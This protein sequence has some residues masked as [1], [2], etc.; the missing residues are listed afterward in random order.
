MENKVGRV[1]LVV[2]SFLIAGAAMLSAQGHAQ[3]VPS[4]KQVAEGA[5]RTFNIPAQ[6]MSS[7]LVLFGQ[8]AGRH[9]TVDGNLVR[10]LSTAGVQGTMAAD[11][12]L[13]RLL[14]GTDLTFSGGAGGTFTVHR[15]DQPGSSGALQLDPVQVQG[16]F[17]VPPTGMIDNIPPPYAG[18]QVATGGQLGL[19]GNR[20]VMDTP[21]NQTSYTAKKAADQQ[22]K[23]VKDVLVDDPSVRSFRPESSSGFDSVYIRG[24]D[25]TADS[26]AYGGLYGMLPSSSVNAE[27]AERV[28]VLKGPS[29]MLNGMP[30][31]GIIGGT[32]NVVPKRAA[33]DDLTQVTAS[34]LSAGQF[35]AHADIG[36]RFGE[37]KQFG[38][39]L[40]ASYRAG[41]TSIDNNTDARGMGVL[42]LDFRGE[43]VRLSADIGY[44]QQYIGGVPATMGPGLGVALPYAPSARLNQGQPWYYLQ[45][46][47]L[48]AVVRAEVDMT[49]SVT[50]Y[51]SFG[52]HDY[53]FAGLYTPSVTITNTNGTA[54]AGAPLNISSY[55]TYVTGEI[56]V[57]AQGHT[58]AIGHEVALSASMYEQVGGLGYVAGTGY[59]TNIYSPATTAVAN[60]ATPAANKTSSSGL[61]S[62]GLADTLTA[63]EKRVQLT[64]G[65]RLQNVVASNYDATTGR[66]TSSYDQSAVSPSLAL[67]LKPFGEK[68]SIYGNWIQGLQ[69][70]TTVPVGFT[71][72]GQIFSPYVATQ[73]EA[74]VKVDWGRFTTTASLFQISRPSILTNAD[75]N[76]QYLG[77]EQVNQGLE[78]NFF[79]EVTEGVRILGGAMFLNAVLTKTQGGLTDG[80]VAPFS[81]AVNLNLAGEW[82]L[83]FVRGLTLNG[84]VIYTGSQYI[85]TT[86]PRRSL[87]DWTRFDIGARYAFDNPGAKGKLLVARFNV[88]NL[89]DASYWQSGNSTTTLFL[90]TA[91]T[92]RLSLSADF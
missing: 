69:Q 85:D 73:F 68:L 2:A 13:R 38:V 92:F 57:R 29:V 71:N 49:E 80:W 28:E 75:T 25:V 53:R 66:Q 41:L 8:Q 89:L 37:D 23:T 39:R 18:G 56:G 9:L 43:H 52:A 35:G 83:P 61:Y 3:D 54:T 64:G 48:F 34:Y 11:E 20:S 82:D 88:E 22:A 65:L 58:G 76:T 26:F 24:F 84:R 50:A 10:S 60:L 12:A 1:G 21:F 67:V 31:L 5:S 6:S 78:F 72:A 27:M 87:P 62:I 4:G 40:N 63:A 59:V 46:K 86:W 90:G 32:V 45:R 30:P 91:R 44:Q 77:G 14:A 81:P 16:V 33:D 70:G 74:G 36:R 55:N 7:A 51:A 42:G 15:L 79:G 19:L 47:D 17:P